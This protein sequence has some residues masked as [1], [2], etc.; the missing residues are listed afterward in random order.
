MPTAHRPSPAT[1][2]VRLARDAVGDDRRSRAAERPDGSYTVQLLDGGVD[3][4]GRKV[5]EEA[6]EV[7]LAAKDDATAERSAADR[8]AP[9]TPWPARRPT[10]SITCSSS[11]PSAACRHRQR[12]MRSGRVTARRG[13]GKPVACSIIEG[14]RT[15]RKRDPERGRHRHTM[16]TSVRHV[17]TRQA[18]FIG[19]G[20]MVGAGIFSLLGAAGEVAGAAVWLSFLLA[21][22]IAALQGYSF[23]KLGARYPAPAGCSNTSTRASGRVMSPQS[24]PG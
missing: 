2:G 7:L 8:P 22:G 19:V 12:S 13:S 3:A 16:A 5:T 17:S 11:S 14:N 1:A 24:P 9:A 18:A 10:S 21:G 15:E 6:T 4:V 20:A 23:A